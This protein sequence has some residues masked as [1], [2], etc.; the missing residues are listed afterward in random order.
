MRLEDDMP[1]I[2]IYA[3]IKIQKPAPIIMD[4]FAGQVYS[5]LKQANVG[6]KTLASPDLES[7]TLAF[8]IYEEESRTGPIF[9]HV[10]CETVVKSGL[11]TRSTHLID[12]DVCGNGASEIQTNTVAMLTFLQA[13]QLLVMANKQPPQPFSNVQLLCK[14][15]PADQW[16][17]WNHKF[18]SRLI[19]FTTQDEQSHTIYA[20]VQR[21]IAMFNELL[22][23]PTLFT[24]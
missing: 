20:S 3:T 18:L 24:P 19:E 8:G 16:S 7:F 13:L 11:S 4:V 10:L 14:V 21:H 15:I 17:R 22:S 6:G 1:S 5:M 9:T 12:T 23:G 2:L